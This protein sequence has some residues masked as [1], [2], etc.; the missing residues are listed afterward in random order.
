MA[1]RAFAQE[2]ND[3]GRGTQPSPPIVA[4][5]QD[6]FVLRSADDAYRLTLGAAVQMDSRVSL[7][8]TTPFT[9]TFLLRKVRPT[10]NGRIAKYFTFRLIPDFANGTTVVQDAYVEVQFSDRLR[11]QTGKA[12]TPIGY[13]SMLGDAYLLFP[14]KSL[15]SAL[16]PS[17]DVGIGLYGTLARGR[18]T[19]G[20]GLFNG[21]P[22]GASSAPADSDANSAK[23]L[24]GR[25]VLVPFTHGP[26][27][28]TGLT[29]GR[30][31]GALPAF[32]TSVGQ[33]YFSYDASVI[34]AG[35]R[36]RESAATFYYRGPFGS[37]TEFV[38][39]RQRVS[40]LGAPSDPDNHAWEA[41][42]S[43][44]LTGEP[45]SDR[46]VRPRRN[47]DPPSH[48]W[49]ALQL[50]ARYS[51]LSVDAN[52]FTSM[53][54]S[55][56]SSPGANAFGIGMNWYLTAYVR[57]YASFERTRF[58]PGPGGRRSDE[59]TIIIRAQLAF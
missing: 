27:F 57:Y 42:A 10:L 41:T 6:G 50:M 22:D 33:T 58:A 38:R 11:L 13:E 56:T 40:R 24:A 17:R 46:G 32:R 12:K 18:L 16:L 47:F 59:H 36:D 35:R 19:Y 7:D 29:Y 31:D 55:A 3:P 8:R 20:S 30:Q 49:G 53:L 54:A 14:E 51:S 48:Q 43:F 26:G 52:A 44:V 2:S 21:V 37:F 1:G 39:S 15:A 9:D 5:W 28:E 4:G 23:D 45:A 34:A 25:V